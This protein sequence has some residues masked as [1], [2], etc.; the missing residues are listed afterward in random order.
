[1]TLEI[2]CKGKKE[3]SHGKAGGRAFQE[4]KTVLSIKWGY[5]FAQSKGQKEIQGDRNLRVIK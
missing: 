1:M 5:E 4:K 3:T 2:R